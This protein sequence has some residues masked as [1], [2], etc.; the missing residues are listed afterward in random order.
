MG[1]SFVEST[2]FRVVFKGKL[3]EDNSVLGGPA[4]KTHL[5]VLDLPDGG[6]P[7]EETLL[8]VKHGA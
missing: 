3:Q 4:K 2:P 7:D 8:G 1:P 6:C 5:H